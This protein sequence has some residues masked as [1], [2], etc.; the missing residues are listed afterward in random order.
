MWPGCTH[1]PACQSLPNTYL[2]TQAVFINPPPLDRGKANLAC[3]REAFHKHVEA[4]GDK[5]HAN[6]KTEVH[7]L[8]ATD[9]CDRAAFCI[10]MDKLIKNKGQE[11]FIFVDETIQCEC[12]CVGSVRGHAVGEITGGKAKCWHEEQHAWMWHITQML[13][14]WSWAGFAETGCNHAPCKI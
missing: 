12:A 9:H 11:N 7:S 1:R 14:M 6:S 4:V 2:G 10:L 13:H 5:L 8:Q 3:F